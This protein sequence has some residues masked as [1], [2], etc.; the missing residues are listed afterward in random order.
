MVQVH[1]L[2]VQIAANTLRR[3]LV[4]FEDAD[5]SAPVESCPTSLEG[6]YLPGDLQVYGKSGCHFRGDL[7]DHVRTGALVRLINL[8]P[9]S[10]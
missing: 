6:L 5:A 8:D 9:Q 10:N 7:L 4:V 2:H 3:P 1:P